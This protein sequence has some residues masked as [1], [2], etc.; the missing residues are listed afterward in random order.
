VGAVKEAVGKGADTAKMV[1]GGRKEKHVLVNKRLA[2]GR[3]GRGRA[4]PELLPLG[5]VMRASSG[6]RC[7]RCTALIRGRRRDG[8]IDNSIVGRGR[9]RVA[10]VVRVKL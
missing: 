4:N 7:R 5:K 9:S 1:E 10:L 8:H 3:V 6:N 2:D